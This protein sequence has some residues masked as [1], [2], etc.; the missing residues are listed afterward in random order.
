MI[1]PH[2]K[3]DKTD[4][5]LLLNRNMGKSNKPKPNILEIVRKFLNWLLVQI[6]N[7]I[8]VS[9]VGILLTFC[10][11]WAGM[12]WQGALRYLVDLLKPLAYATGIGAIFIFLSLLQY[13]LFLILD[14]YIRLHKVLS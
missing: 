11:L 6:L 7:T 13:E 4:S 1:K 2:C 9:A 3:V 8:L 14:V 12:G 5:K 10:V